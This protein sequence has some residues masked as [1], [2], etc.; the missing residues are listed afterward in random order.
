MFKGPCHC[1]FRR[2]FSQK[3]ALTSHFSHFDKCVILTGLDVVPT[4][5][6]FEPRYKLWFV[7]GVT[8]VCLADVS[9]RLTR[10]IFR[11]VVRYSD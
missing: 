11:L 9:F 1:A 6:N 5:A 3:I 7:T 8:G 4:L 2:I 10:M